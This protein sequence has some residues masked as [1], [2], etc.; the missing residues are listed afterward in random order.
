MRLEPYW[1]KFSDITNQFFLSIKFATTLKPDS[2]QRPARVP[3][4][5]LNQNLRPHL[6][7][8]S[9]MTLKKK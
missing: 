1:Y 5:E 7:N 6:L 2:G 4:M 3:S 9:R 8:H